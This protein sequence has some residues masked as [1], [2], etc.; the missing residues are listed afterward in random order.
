MLID[1]GQP[2]KIVS[3]SL[4]ISI[5]IH[6]LMIRILLIKEFENGTYSIKSE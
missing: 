3:T 5:T 1:I 4:F 6:Y 2:R